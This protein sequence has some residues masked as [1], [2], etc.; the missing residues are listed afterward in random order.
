MKY[1]AQT[2]VYSNPSFLG[3]WSGLY[4]SN[5]GSNSKLFF[6]AIQNQS[7]KI[8]NDL[9][10][11][12]T[13]WHFN[14]PGAP[15]FGGLWEAAVKSAKYHLVRVIGKKVPTFVELSMVLEKNP[16]DSEFKASDGFDG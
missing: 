3:S 16:S 15:H 2:M 4:R 11:N 12:N 7:T 9:R 13:N 1:V 5:K 6:E 8:Y 14:P 10:A